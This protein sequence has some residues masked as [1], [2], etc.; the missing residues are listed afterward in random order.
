MA[1]VHPYSALQSFLQEQ[2]HGIYPVVDFDAVESAMEQAEDPFLV[3]EEIIAQENTVGFGSPD[4]MCVRES[5]SIAVHCFSPAPHGSNA[6]RR[7][8]DEVRNTLRF[9]NLDGVRITELSA[10][11]PGE[12]MNAGLWAA[13]ALLVSYEWDSQYARPT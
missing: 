3:L 9:R 4:G 12:L 7:I 5:G 1:G 6:T 11:D 8:A 13:A 10:P 2:F